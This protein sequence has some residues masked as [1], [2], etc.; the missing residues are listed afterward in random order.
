MRHPRPRAALLTLALAAACASK[1]EA[2]PTAAAGLCRALLDAPPHEWHQRLPPVLALGRAGATPL[3][4]QLHMAPLSPGAQAA[5][6]A[7][8]NLGDPAAIPW[9]LQQVQ[10]RS[11][12][13]TEA[14]LSLGRLPAPGARA[15]LQTTLA[16][17]G[18]AVDL[19]TACACALLELGETRDAVPFLCALFAAD[20]NF[21]V[22]E[23]AAAGLGSRPRWALERQMA[24][25]AIAKACGGQTFGLDPDSPWPRLEQGVRA[26]RE[27]FAAGR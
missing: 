4:E 2:A 1:P 15:V 19:R 26:L 22:A 21:G 20:T 16:D 23:A 7:L 24:L 27:H 12:L 18:A 6:G 11:G 9:L 3:L 25:S 17:H 10:A 5:V 8:G 13:G 14:A